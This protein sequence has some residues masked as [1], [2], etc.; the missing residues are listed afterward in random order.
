MRGAQ[1]EVKYHAHQ[2]KQRLYLILILL[3]YEGH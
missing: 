1:Q 3:V 2:R